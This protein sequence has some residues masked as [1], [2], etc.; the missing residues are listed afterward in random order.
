M[1]K[2]TWSKNVS[3][4]EDLERI[5]E[6]RALLNKILRRKTSRIGHI[7]K[8][9]CLLYDAIEGE[10][11]EVKEVGRIRKQLLDYLRNRRRY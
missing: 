11:R 6:N 10:M 9:D 8:I 5:G 3:N 1:E 4:E 7:L 2:I